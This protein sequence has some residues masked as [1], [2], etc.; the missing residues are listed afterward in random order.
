MFNRAC[1]ITDEAEDIEK[2]EDLLNAVL[3]E[4][5]YPRKFVD[6]ARRIPT[7]KDTTDQEPPKATIVL[8]YVRGLSEDIRRECTKHNIRVALKPETTIRQSLVRVKDPV[9]KEQRTNVVYEVPCSCSRSYIGKTIQTLK[10]R[11]NQHRH[12]EPGRSALTDHVNEDHQILW[13]EA[14]II[15]QSEN[16]HLLLLKESL[17]IRLRKPEEKLNRDEGVDIPDVWTLTLRSMQSRRGD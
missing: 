10:Q 11:L 3:Q 12:A 4:N 17:H 6:R 14:K 5:G 15:D 8:P 1:A 9:P 7:R 13:D 2:E 16:H